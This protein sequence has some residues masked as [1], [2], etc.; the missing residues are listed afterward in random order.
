MHHRTELAGAS[1]S[2][3]WGL[4]LGNKYISTCLEKKTHSNSFIFTVQKCIFS[5]T[6][7]F[8]ASG[9]RASASEGGSSSSPG[10]GHRWWIRVM[11]HW[12]TVLWLTPWKTGTCTLEPGRPLLKES[13]ERDEGL[14]SK[15][16][17]LCWTQ[18][19]ISRTQEMPLWVHCR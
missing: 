16:M 4:V 8:V 2:Q 11:R 18:Q 13:L 7:P 5:R 3:I 17:L 9:S 12:K 19:N 1:Q 10:L 14:W 6:F 15:H